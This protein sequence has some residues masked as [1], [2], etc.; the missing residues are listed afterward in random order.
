MLSTNLFFYLLPEMVLSFAYILIV[1]VAFISTD[2]YKP[3]FLRRFT[4]IL[5][6][7]INCECL[8]LYIVMP[9]EAVA[10]LHNMI[11]ITPFTI[12]FKM[13][14]LLLS[15]FVLLLL[16]FPSNE[17]QRWRETL[18]LIQSTTLG[19]I[20]SMCAAN[21]LFLYV[22]IEL[23]NI[24]AYV[25]TVTGTARQ[26]FEAGTKYFLS[27]SF[28]SGLNLIAIGIFYSIFGTLNVIEISYLSNF[29]FPFSTFINLHL[30]IA[31]LM[32][33][34][35]FKA[36][37]VPFHLWTADVYQNTTPVT[38]A[39]LATVSKAAALYHLY[40]I[41]GI[42]PGSIVFIKNTYFIIG[43]ISLLIGTLAV[44]NQTNIKRLFAYSSIVHSGIILIL[45]SYGT[46]E[47]FL[48]AFFYFS[49]YCFM[50]LCFFTSLQSVVSH[51]GF[52]PIHDIKD[53]VR[54]S[55]P[56]YLL[57]IQFTLTFL[58]FAGIPPLIGFFPKYFVVDTLM[59]T[60]SYNT[61]L[62]FIICSAMSTVYYLKLIMAVWS[63]GTIKDF[64][65]RKWSP[66]I[67]IIIGFQFI[68]LL[69]IPVFLYPYFQFF[70]LVL[71]N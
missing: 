3:K 16:L 64:L 46:V 51:N 12:L 66:L 42:F 41:F 28:M 36:S 11:C 43:L 53:L 2:K 23:S 19:F 45:F 5:T 38:T 67:Y 24:G 49:C 29:T 20:F 17:D 69:Y 47:T 4:I 34:Q 58:S 37:A 71:F 56:H 15:T 39:Y 10:L 61:L 26:R 65:A 59:A 6:I 1:F 8:Y 44:F 13:G 18:L 52:S 60:E 48:F 57:E 31:F 22:A 54:F 68:V 35:L 40:T 62:F 55:K 14:T 70:I 33:Y 27:T 7:L 63:S 50:V 32:S 9:K 30:A 21:F 25:L